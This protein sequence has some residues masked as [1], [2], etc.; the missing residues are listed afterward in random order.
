MARPPR[1]SLS[2]SVSL[3]VS[4]ETVASQIMFTQEARSQPAFVVRTQEILIR[5]PTGTWMI[6]T[7][8]VALFLI[9]TGTLPGDRKRHTS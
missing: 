6:E 3:H 5:N 9:S 7:P 4:A 8:Q 1:S 2:I